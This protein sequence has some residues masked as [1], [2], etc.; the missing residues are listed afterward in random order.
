RQIG[1]LGGVLIPQVF[2]LFLQGTAFGAGIP[3]LVGFRLD[4]ECLVLPLQEVPGFA[5][6]GLAQRRAVAVF[7]ALLVGRT[8]ANDGLATDQSRLVGVGASLLDGIL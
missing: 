6:F 3:G 5:D 1:I 4:H 7:L 2:P 8:I